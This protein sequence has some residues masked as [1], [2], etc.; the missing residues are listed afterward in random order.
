MS[1]R[2][3]GPSVCIDG[4]RNI[5]RLERIVSFLQLVLETFAPRRHEYSLNN[6]L[7]TI[8]HLRSLP[9]PRRMRVVRVETER[10]FQVVFGFIHLSDTEEG[11]AP[12]RTRWS[13]HSDSEIAGNDAVNCF[14]CTEAARNRL[15]FG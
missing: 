13:L 8:H 11:L 14:T 6:L 12:A 5:S 3:H 10:F 4:L 9:E 15:G 1:T 2:V 7:Q